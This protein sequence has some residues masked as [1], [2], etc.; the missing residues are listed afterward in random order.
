M[1]HIAFYITGHGFGHATRM[2]AV[3][4]GVVRRTGVPGRVVP[5][6]GTTAEPAGK[7]ATTAA[8]S[9]DAKDS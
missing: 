6:V 3:A 1:P 2:G 8:A 9:K 5:G 4:R 7:A